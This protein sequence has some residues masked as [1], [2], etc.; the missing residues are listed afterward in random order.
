MIVLSSGLNIFPEDM[1]AV[2]AKHPNVADAAVVGLM[3]GSS[4]EVHAALILHN[5]DAAQEVIAWTNAQLAEQQRIR[6]SPFG[7]TRTFPAL[8]PSK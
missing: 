5:D 1:E 3:R 8:T 2:L 6:A 7:L 4:V